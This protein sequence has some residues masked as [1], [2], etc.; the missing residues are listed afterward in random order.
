MGRCLGGVLAGHVDMTTSIRTLA[1]WGPSFLLVLANCGTTQPL[2]F[3]RAST[4]PNLTTP[5]IIYDQPSTKQEYSTGDKRKSTPSIAVDVNGRWSHSRLGKLSIGACLGHNCGLQLDLSYVLKPGNTEIL[6]FSILAFGG[7]SQ[8]GIGFSGGYRPGAGPFAVHFNLIGAYARESHDA[9]VI[10]SD[11]SVSE[12]IDLPI[13]EISSWGTRVEAPIALELTLGRTH[14][15]IGG[16]TYW[17]W[18][19]TSL[20]YDAYF[21]NNDEIDSVA[22]E[23]SGLP[24]RIWTEVVISLG[25]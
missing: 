8:S 9:P 11:G 2:A 6:P 12:R 15:L 19:N 14:F 25:G 16:S 3:Y 23:R 17:K 13:A 5:R 21:D 1:F 20:N 4:K 24:W 22:T 7:V 18:R 10:F